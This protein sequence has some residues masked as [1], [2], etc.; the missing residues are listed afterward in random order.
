MKKCKNCAWVDICEDQGT[1][2]DHYYNEKEEISK[3]EIR[4]RE[5]NR[6]MQKEYISG[7]DDEEV[8]I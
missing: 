8:S 6:E 2:C 5:F 3:L 1:A 4:Y 7:I